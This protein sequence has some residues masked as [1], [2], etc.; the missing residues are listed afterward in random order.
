MIAETAGKFALLGAS[1]YDG[2]KNPVEAGSIV[3]SLLSSSNPEYT[4]SGR[5][6]MY[7][8]NSGELDSK[9]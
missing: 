2:P 7:I 4:S 3:E 5:R 9:F 1:G 8:I 6:I